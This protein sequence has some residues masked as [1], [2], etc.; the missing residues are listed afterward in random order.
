MASVY[1]HGMFEVQQFRVP[2]KA[3]YKKDLK[4]KS[5]FWEEVKDLMLEGDLVCSDIFVN[6]QNYQN[7]DLIV[8]EV[9][10]GGEALKVGMIKTI[11]VRGNKVCFVI[12]QYIS[13]RDTLGY[14]ESKNVDAEF[15]VKDSTT[16]ADNK[17]LIM[18]G[19]VTKFQFV[20]HHHISFDHN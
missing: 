14:Y 18:R 16:L 2:E 20:L 13:V 5:Q 19:T 8:N 9:L 7:G 15:L 12:K 11:L 10:E 6:S 3:S 17:P 1:Y 4:Q